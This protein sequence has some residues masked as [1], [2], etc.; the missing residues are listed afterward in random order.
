MKK[1]KLKQEEGFTIVELMI[2]T[3]VLSVML[4]IVTVLMINIGSLLN[5][6]INQANVQDDLRNITSDIAQNV[7]YSD[8]VIFSPNTPINPVTDQI[9]IAPGVAYAICIG[10]MRYTY[11][12]GTQIGTP[13]NHLGAT[14]DHILWR[15]TI[16]GS[17]GSCT[18]VNLTIA[19]P[20]VMSQ[21]GTNGQEL[22]A[23]S[24]RLTEFSVTYNSPYTITIG[25][26]YGSS[27]LLTA[28]YNSPGTNAQCSGGTGDQFCSTAILQ[29][30][31]AQRLTNS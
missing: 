17:S 19:D 11:V 10:T 23:A 4:L 5:K 22:I 25:L 13:Y 26:A 3:A 2:A 16:A 21:P 12:I 18:P 29:T 28:N 14:F 6:G 24:S 1:G 8:G 20:N 9:T 31:V 27:D 30:T 7:E 15:D